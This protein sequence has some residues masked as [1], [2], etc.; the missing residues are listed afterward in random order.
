MR[1]ALAPARDHAPHLRE[2]VHQVRLRV[3]ATR[4][5]DEHDAV[6]GTDRVVGDRRRIAAALA[7]D[8]ARAR[9]LGPDLELLLGRRAEGVGG[10][11]RHR[12]PVLAQLL[13]ELADRRRLAGAVDA[14]DEDHR[15]LV[16][17]VERRRLTEERG[18]LLRERA[19]ELAQVLPRLEAPDQLRGRA[20][21]D[22]RVDQRLL[23]PLPRRVVL[24]IERRDDDLL[25]ERTARL[26]ERLAQAAEETAA[27]LVGLGARVRL[28]QQ[29]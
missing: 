15:R 24:G 3:Q 4:G 27:L 5:V 29:L 1:R 12:A 13:R 20:H 6:V 10:A 9:A 23:E 18:D 8:E 2:L 21:A 22:V 7:A 16:R 26:A 17:D 11:E 25:G 19:R 28:A 14:D